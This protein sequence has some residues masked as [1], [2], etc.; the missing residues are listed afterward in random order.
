[1]S[2]QP[3]LRIALDLFDDC[4]IGTCIMQSRM[5]TTRNCSCVKKSTLLHLTL[6]TVIWALGKFM[7]EIT[8]FQYQNMQNAIYTQ[9]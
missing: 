8:E 6:C 5:W 2:I 4:H 1:M 3:A 7:L 9:C